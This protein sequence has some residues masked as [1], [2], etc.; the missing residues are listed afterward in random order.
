LMPSDITGTL[1]PERGPDGQTDLR[2]RPGPIFHQLL[3]ADEINRATPKTQ[4]AMLEA[5]AEYQVTVLGETHNLRRE[6][7]VML[8]GAVRKVRP[9]FMVMATQNPIDQEGTHDLPEAQS[10]RFMFKILMR[11]PDS[12]I[13]AR[14]VR[15]ELTGAAS[16]R[17]AAEPDPAAVARLQRAALAV[18]SLALPGAVLAQI[19]NM[20]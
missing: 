15:K 18:R 16:S 17:S 6:R 3:I 12:A 2:F 11:M 1:M 5:M 4:A 10:D 20:V 9:P 14:I 8:D 19:L 7:S 13:L